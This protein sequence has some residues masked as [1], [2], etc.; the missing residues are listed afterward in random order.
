MWQK[1]KRRFR[2]GVLNAAN[3]FKCSKKMKHLIRN[4]TVIMM[5]IISQI[6]NLYPEDAW[7]ECRPEDRK[8]SLSFL[9]HMIPFILTKV[10]AAMW[11]LH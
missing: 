1:K 10:E 11:Y 3:F 9:S 6:H 4:I 8:A 5:I 2:Y 7:F